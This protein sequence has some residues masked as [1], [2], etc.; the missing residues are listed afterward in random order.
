LCTFS[1]T[2]QYH[3]GKN[4]L[5]ANALSRR[6]HCDIVNDLTS[7]KDQI[8]QFA[9]YHSPEAANSTL[10]SNNVIQAIC[11][12]YSLCQA[13]DRNCITHVESLSM[14]PEAIP[15]YYEEME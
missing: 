5:D 12:K 7:Q 1:F 13:G 4:N 11:D 2:L 15:E 9:L 3:P 6:P 14:C 8:R 10:V